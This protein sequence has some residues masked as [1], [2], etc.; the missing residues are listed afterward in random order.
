MYERALKDSD[1]IISMYDWGKKNHLIQVW[2][3]RGRLVWLEMN[4]QRSVVKNDV[5]SEFVNASQHEKG[6]LLFCFACPTH[7]IRPWT[8]GG[9]LLW[10]QWSRLSGSVC[11]FCF[12][13][14]ALTVWQQSEIL[15]RMQGEKWD[16]HAAS[17]DV[18]QLN[19]H[20]YFCGMKSASQCE[21]LF[22]PAFLCNGHDLKSYIKG[23]V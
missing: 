17:G 15:A 20:E 3:K 9:I 13:P 4:W 6:H 8:Y 23:C 11:C 22:L 21:W 12:L 10:F 19:L 5:F 1:F 14:S 7:F 16:R 18:D 2:H